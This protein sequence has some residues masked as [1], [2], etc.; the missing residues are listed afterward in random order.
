MNKI[1][2]LR[3]KMSLNQTEL[4]NKIGVSQSTLSYWERGDFEPDHESL[5]NLADIFDVSI[6]YLLGR[7]SMPFNVSN[8]GIP[9]PVLG[10]IPAG[11][12][13]EAIE[14]IIDYE[15]VPADWIIGGKEYFAL[16]VKGDSMF[17]KYLDGDTVIFLKTDSCDS[18]TE[19]AV[20]VNG[21]DATFKKVI[22]KDSGIVLQPLNGTAFDPVLYTNEEVLS[23]P[24]SV[25]GI[26]KEL[27][28]K[29]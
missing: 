12:P 10:R 22:K 8:K 13:I 20:I 6:D 4:A 3:K 9:I 14:D 1:S 15:E 26:A 11:I 17:P 7:V 25:I 16:K 24:V 18:G 2:E 21:T 29:M 28:R 5:I 23:L 19:C 27:R